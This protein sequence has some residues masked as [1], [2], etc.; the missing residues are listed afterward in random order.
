MGAEA[1]AMSGSERGGVPDCAPMPPAADIPGALAKTEHALGALTDSAR[2]ERIAVAC[3]E[4]FVPALR[5][6]GGSGD[7]QRDGVGGPL[8]GDGG[9]VVL[10]VSL[11]VRWAKKVERDLDGLAGHGHKPRLVIAVTNRTTG[12]KRRNQLEADAR[13]NRRLELRIIDVKFLALRLLSPPLLAFREELLGLSVP[14]LPV[15]VDAVQFARRQPDIG[16]PDELIGRSDEIGVLVGLLAAHQTVEVTGAGG[17]GKTRLVLEAQSRIGAGRALFLDD[18]ARLDSDL[19]GSELAGGDQLTLVVDNAHRREDLRQVVGS[20]SARTGVTRLVLIA[21]HG[22]D[23]RLRQATEGSAFGVVGATGRMSVE[24]MSNREIGALIRATEPKLEFEGAIEQIVAV[25]AGNPLIALLAHRV[26]SS[27][28]G[29]HGLAFNDLLGE[30]AQSAIAAA[31]QSRPDAQDDDLHDV[32][33]VAA[34]LGPIGPAE[35]DLVASLLGLSVRTVRHR[36]ADLADAGLLAHSGEQFAIA[37]DLLGAHLLQQAYLCG[38]VGSGVR[39]GEIWGA[40]SEDRRDVMCSALGGL[41][42]FDVTGGAVVSAVVGDAL[43]ALASVNAVRALARAQ[44]LAPG[45]PDVALRVVDIAIA[46]LPDGE[47]AGERALLVAME[48]LSRVSDVSVGWPRQLAVAQA[49]FAGP[50]TEAA[51]KKIHEALTTVYKRLPRDTSVYDGHVLAH[52]QD[53]LADATC[54]YWDAHRGDP[55]C[56]RTVALAAGQLLTVVSERSYISAED[57]M[58]IKLSAGFLPAGDRTA[59]VL[60]AGGRLLLASIAALKLDEQQSAVRPIAELR[61]TARGFSGPFAATPPEELVTLAGH[62]LEELA[63]GLTTLNELPL[64]TRAALIDALG[65]EPWPCDE[66]LRDFRALLRL[67]RAHE[68]RAD[69]GAHAEHH[70]TVLLSAND[71]VVELCRWQTWLSL[72]QRA[73]MRHGAQMIVGPALALAA[74]A[75]PDRIADALEA[76][77][78]EAGPLASHAAGALVELVGRPDGEA[79][80]RRLVLSSTRRKR[81]APRSPAAWRARRSRGPM[82]FLRSS[83]TVPM[84][85]YA[86]PSRTQPAGHRAARRDDCAPGCAHACPPMSAA[87]CPC[88]LA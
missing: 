31:V 53:V 1:W 32:L 62:V 44:S 59:R 22:Y 79:F 60:H 5:N 24:A 55:G 66:E 9:Q 30:Y 51:A 61:R 41:H 88:S 10:S 85:T 74:R 46:R 87:R 13:T 48:V 7:E 15:A 80:M 84:S 38:P 73:G 75:E 76:V 16:A 35:D 33:A 26:A 17:V 12:A 81:R 58:M 78:A 3:L 27:R 23:E 45:L 57:D 8:L 49:F 40:A 18:R 14:Q 77:L 54:V 6:T 2:F 50:G 42:G 82:S 4:E 28:G 65:S 29:L 68:L 19:L 21:R 52:V 86:G 20:L 71:P 56:E 83:P 34:A 25:A 67:P 11:E 64:P 72:A 39:Y 69:G 47:Q 37:P 70:A 36:I 43:A 63:A